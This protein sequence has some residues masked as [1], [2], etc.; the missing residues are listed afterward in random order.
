MEKAGPSETGF[1]IRP[2]SPSDLDG[3]VALMADLGY[4]TTAAELAARMA[5]MPPEFYHTFVAEAAGEVV[6]FI[7]LGTMPVFEMDQPMGWVLALSVAS[8]HRRKGI[9]RALLAEAEAHCLSLGIID[10]RLHSGIQRS[11]AHEFYDTVGYSKT[12][13]RFKKVLGPHS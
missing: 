5:R 10:V 6:G 12:G 4:P 11:E 9:G 8:S 2:F 3:M 1:Q 7:G 13:Y